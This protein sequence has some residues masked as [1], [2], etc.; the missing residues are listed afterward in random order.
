MSYNTAYGANDDNPAPKPKGLNR[1]AYTEQQ[2][3]QQRTDALKAWMTGATYK[4]IGKNLGIS[5]GTAYKRVQD[6]I[7]EMRPHSDYDQYRA[8]QLAELDVARRPFRTIIVAWRRG[9]AVDE[10]ATALAAL[11]KIQEREA[12]LLGL[13][14]A[15]TP[16]EELARQVRSMS[17]DELADM[18]KEFVADATQPEP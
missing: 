15:P 14:R 13:D 11:L 12:K 4:T 9:E 7:D 5:T 1:Y 16:E 2:R 10:I 6:A 8:I 17:D 3:V 18:L